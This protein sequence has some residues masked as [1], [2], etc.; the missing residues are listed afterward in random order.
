MFIATLISL[1]R[2]TFNR[3]THWPSEIR[4]T[5]KPSQSTSEENSMRVSLAVT[6]MFPPHH[7]VAG[8]IWPTWKPYRHQSAM[9]LHLPFQL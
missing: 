9:A 5:A 3:S 2:V 8:M 4:W 1:H 6:A 7:V